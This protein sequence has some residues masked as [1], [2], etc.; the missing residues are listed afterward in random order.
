MDQE[1]KSKEGRV[2]T[3][4]LWILSGLFCGLAFIM[5]TGEGLQSLP[6]FLYMLAI[7]LWFNPIVRHKVRTCLWEKGERT[8]L[9]EEGELLRLL[10]SHFFGIQWGLFLFI[11]VFPIIMIIANAQIAEYEKY[12][13]LSPIQVQELKDKEA[14]I[15]AEKQAKEEAQAAEEAKQAQIE[16]DKQEK[17]Q[18]YKT[19]IEGKSVRALYAKTKRND[20][21]DNGLDIKINV[22][23]AHNEIITF[24]YALFN[25]VWSHKFQKEGVIDTLQELGFKKV[26]MT[27]G[28]NWGCSWDLG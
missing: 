1:K 3:V 26:K 20:F 16:A 6:S 21:L 7:G 4:I 17:E 13:G 25:D 12:K 19:F 14:R 8:R 24:K 11:I 10:S 2:K 9:P 5:K 18:A 28:Y 23:G 15:E 27:D 22:Q